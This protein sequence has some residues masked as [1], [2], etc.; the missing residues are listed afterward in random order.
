MY[1]VLYRKPHT[2]I[3][4]ATGDPPPSF[5]VADSQYERLPSPKIT[6]TWRVDEQSYP[7]AIFCRLAPGHSWPA[8]IEMLPRMTWEN[9][10][11]VFW[12]T[13]ERD[14]EHRDLLCD[15]AVLYRSGPHSYAFCFSL[16]GIHHPSV[17]H[18]LV[19]PKLY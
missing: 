6:A 14:F 16:L 19:W 13:T 11:L 10:R 5:D 1:L 8:D 3:G 17:G 12:L 7:V 18:P 15:D 2:V 9:D 4:F